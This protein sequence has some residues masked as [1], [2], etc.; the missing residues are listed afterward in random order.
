M[1]TADRY[2]LW[3]FFA[4]TA[5]MLFL[6][7]GIY[8]LSEALKESRRLGEAGI[9]LMEL[10]QYLALRV[11]GILHEMAPFAVLLGTLVWL[12]DLARNAELTALRAGGMS[13]A[14]MARP[15]LLGGLVVAAVSF[16]VND[17]IATRAEAFGERILN[18]GQGSGAEA[19]R[20]W[21]SS[22]GIWFRD[23]P[24]MVSV[25]QVRRS[26]RELRGVRLYR[27]GPNGLVTDVIS[28]DSVVFREGGWVLP[29]GYA[30]EL[31]TLEASPLRDRALALRARPEVMADL[32]RS[33]ERMTF[34]Q[35]WTYAEQLRRQRQP[36]AALSFTLWQKV[37][38]SLACAVMV[39]VAIPF[40]TLTPRS[41]GRVGRVLAGIGL[42]L[43]FHASNVLAENLSAVAGISAA[44][45]AWAPLVA[46][47]GLGSWL[48]YRRR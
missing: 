7:A 22:G 28:G 35:L 23:E 34:P 19:S 5:L 16:A 31:A 46:F 12:S 21:L 3:G 10:G 39:L 2:L 29:R 42:G 20:Q 47:G 9:G 41:G 4:K 43:A 32:G 24:Y 6:L 11:P 48:L 17:R 15:L 33:P 14:R 26:G 36:V 1:K 40:V 13:L 37:T 44:M 8:V 27:L 18:P 38:R 45:A 30:V 25:D